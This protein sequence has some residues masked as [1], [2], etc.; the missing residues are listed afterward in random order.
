VTPGVVVLAAAL[1]GFGARSVWPKAAPP[2][3]AQAAIPVYSAQV[4][5]TDVKQRQVEPGTIG[6][7]GTCSVA[8]ELPAGVITALPRAG[9]ILT[10]GQVLYRI[11]HPGLARHRPGQHPRSGH[12]GTRREP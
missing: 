12:Q 11:A 8:D 1:A 5:R 10:R 4:I 2:T 6:Y 9:Q 3:T 7:Q